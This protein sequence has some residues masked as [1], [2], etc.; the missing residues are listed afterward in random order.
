MSYNLDLFDVRKIFS[1][2]YNLLIYNINLQSRDSRSGL[3]K[4]TQNESYLVN[5]NGLTKTECCSNWVL[6]SDK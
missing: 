3:C 6:I 4:R 2:I 5:D 1:L